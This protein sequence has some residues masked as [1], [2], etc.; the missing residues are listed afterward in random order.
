M[1][2]LFASGELFPRSGKN[3][4]KSLK[5]LEERQFGRA[6]DMNNGTPDVERVGVTDRK[7]EK[8]MAVEER[9]E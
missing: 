6:L 5:E 2:G 8:D 7:Q 9:I 4:L 3:S 1:E